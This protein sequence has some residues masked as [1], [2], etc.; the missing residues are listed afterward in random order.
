MQEMN[1]NDLH[2]SEAAA[3]N[4]KQIKR[5]LGI[6]G[7]LTLVAAAAITASL[8]WRDA[9]H[10]HN[11]NETPSQIITVAVT[12]VWGAI[13]IFFWSMK[14]SP[15]LSYRRYLREIHSGISRDVEGVIVSMDE[16]TAFR[17]GLNFYRMIVNV[18]DLNEEE[19]ERV[20]YWDA[21][22]GRPELSVGDS[23]AVRAH[24][25]DIISLQWR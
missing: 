15:R 13:I 12:L 24:G 1:E 10:M 2:G 20:L 11:P 7:L 14:L 4:G 3:R 21:Q 9:S 22:L 6:F 17:E 8:I 18:G 5:V 25:N 19:D 23:V 16:D